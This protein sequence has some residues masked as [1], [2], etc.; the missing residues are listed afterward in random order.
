MRVAVAQLRGRRPESY[1]PARARDVRINS[2][3]LSESSTRARGTVSIGNRPRCLAHS[4]TMAL[5]TALLVAAT[6]PGRSF[7]RPA[8]MAFSAS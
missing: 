6:E 5:M 3:G 4:V 1:A 2:G 8:S 7:A